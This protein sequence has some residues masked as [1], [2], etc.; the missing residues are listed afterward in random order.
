MNL[1]TGVANAIT[2]LFKPVAKL[3]DDVHTS[4]EERLQLRNGL[5]ELQGKI[6]E[7][8][9]DF[10]EKL[11]EAQRA[12]IIAEI[13]GSWLTQNWRPILM[14]GIMGMVFNNYVLVPYLNAIFNWSVS[15]VLPDKLFNLLTAGVGGYVGGRTVEKVVQT[16]KGGNVIKE[17]SPVVGPIKTILG[18]FKKSG[19]QDG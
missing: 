13:Q 5:A 3:V 8:V 6:I 15:V 10:A 1:I 12:I 18:K 7:R 17:S 9:L 14:L 11:V 4:D 2:G 19:G 16:I